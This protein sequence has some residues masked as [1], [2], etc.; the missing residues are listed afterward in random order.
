MINTI[1]LDASPGRACVEQ[2]EPELH[3]EPEPEPEPERVPADSHTFAA[4]G[5]KAD[6]RPHASEAAQLEES[7]LTA[8][9]T[10]QQ[11]AQRM[12]EMTNRWVALM[13]D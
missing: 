5:D 11:L 13:D 9:Y 12:L 3:P 10:A 1:G 4:R 2:P 8:V 6:V 7:Y